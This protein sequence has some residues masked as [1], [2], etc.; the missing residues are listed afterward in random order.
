MKQ[1]LTLRLPREAL[2][3]PITYRLAIDYDVA[4]K[5]IRAR[6]G[7][8][9]EGVMVVELAG[10]IDDLA[11]ATA[12]LRQQG[13]VVTTAVGQLSIDPDRC[14][15]CGI[16]TTVCPTGALHMERPRWSLQF[17]TRRCVV[18]EQCIP[19]CPLGAISLNLPA[20]SDSKVRRPHR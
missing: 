10:D 8:D 18:C 9:Q 4:S 2:N 14:V 13:L 11:A 6:I 1:R 15:D 7:P 16:C 3:Q 20:P 12:W 5:I 17:E 19:S